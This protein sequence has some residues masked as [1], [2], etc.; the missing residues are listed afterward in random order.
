MSEWLTRSPFRPRLALTPS[1][2]SALAVLW[3]WA[4][5]TAGIIAQIRQEKDTMIQIRGH[6]S[7]VQL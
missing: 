1:A 6:S 4:T 7:I 3:F 5:I 2:L